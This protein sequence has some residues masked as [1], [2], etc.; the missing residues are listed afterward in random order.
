MSTS[1][2]AERQASG[3]KLPGWAGNTYHG[4]C[5]CRRRARLPLS[6]GYLHAKTISV[7]SEICSIGSANIDIRSFS[8]NYELN[9]V[10]YSQRL[11]KELEEDFKRDLADCSEFDLAAYHNSTLRFDSV[12]GCSAA[13]SLAVRPSNCHSG[14]FPCPCL[15]LHRVMYPDIRIR[16]CISQIRRTI[17][18]NTPAI[19]INLFSVPNNSTRDSHGGLT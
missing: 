6:K 3:N 12:T 16:L 8:I 1:G 2:D 7:D 15:W 10:L 19:W 4:R 5:C 17:T 9:A 14:L 13:L 11:A 18:M